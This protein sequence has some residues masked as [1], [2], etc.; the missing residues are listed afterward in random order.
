MMASATWALPLGLLRLQGFM[1]WVS[2]LNLSSKHSVRRDISG[3]YMRTVALCHWEPWALK[4]T[5][6]Q[7][8]A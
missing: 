4:E 8:L 7:L 6:A 2:Y 3:A 1:R 5:L